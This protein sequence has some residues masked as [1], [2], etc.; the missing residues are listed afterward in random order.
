M[1]SACTRAVLCAGLFAAPVAAQDFHTEIDLFGLGDPL[2]PAKPFG[3]TYEPVSDRLFV[4]LSGDF[5]GANRAVVII[6]PLTDT[7]VGTIDVGLFPEDIAFA[8]DA[9][10]NVLFGAVTNSTDGSIT[11]WDAAD[12]VVATVTLPDAFGLG[13]CY[14]FGIVAKDG[15]FYVSTQDG[16]GD[17]HA[18]NWNTQTYDAG[19]SFNINFRSGSRMAV[20][21]DSLWIPSTEFLPAFE[22]GKGG[23]Y[24]HDLQGVHADETW[25]AAYADQFLGYPSGQ[26]IAVLSDGSAYLTGLDFGGRLFKVDAQGQLDR[27]I[28]CEGVDGYG[29]AVSADETLMAVAGLVANE[30]LL[31]DLLNQKLLSRTDV[32]GLGSGSMQPNDVVF[33]QGK[34]YVTVQ[35]SERVLVFDNLPTVSGGTAYQGTL[36]L[37]DSTPLRGDQITIDL[38]GTAGFPVA[39]MSAMGTTPTAHLG[40]AFEIG[41]TLTRRASDLSGSLQVSLSIPQNPILE[42]KTFFLQGYVAD[43]SGA[44]VTAPKVMVIQ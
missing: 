35:S 9:L 10:G 27:A 6:D 12:Q 38:T 22:G 17:V 14:P 7:V 23:L 39:L 20:Q 1:L 28:D 5:A 36:A 4:A 31:I 41:S 34:L 33:A 16:S 40:V 19:A 32:V 29:L 25:F 30:V 11:I 44:H 37:S 18:V 26:D 15:H 13:T 43:A 42:G 2:A 8:Y 3:I 21:G 24:T